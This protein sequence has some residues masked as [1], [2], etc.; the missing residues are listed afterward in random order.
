MLLLKTILGGDLVTRYKVAFAVLLFLVFS[1]VIGCINGT[2]AYAAP[3]TKVTFG[4]GASQPSQTH[5][6]FF[7]AK[8]LGYWEEEGIDAQFEWTQGSSQAIQLLGAGRI[9]FS[10]ANHDTLIFAVQQGAKLKAVFQEHTKCEFVFAVPKDSPLASI[11]DLKGKIIGVSS[12]SS[13]FVSFAKAAFFEAGM[14][15]EKDLN[16]VEVGSGATA[17]TAISTGQVDALGLWEVAF[18]NLENTLGYDYFRYIKPPIYDRL[19]CNAVMTSDEFINSN[20]QGLAGFL[21][22]VAKGTLFMQ[23]NPE[24]AIKIFFKHVPEAKPQ[25]KDD[26]TIMKEA[27]HT[28]LSENVQRSNQNRSQQNPNK[29]WGY[30]VESEFTAAQDVHFQMGVLSEKLPASSYMENKFSEEINGF[31]SAAVIKQAQEYKMQQ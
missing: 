15:Y 7:V 2:E 31:D 28:A 12:L 30:L 13:G 8:E 29:L 26:E 18:A 14:D 23:T 25:G 11:E 16:L 24:A 5:T 22:G 20:P 10:A 6:P 19:A 9:D 27:M 3:S 1:L 4:F 21:R 17:A